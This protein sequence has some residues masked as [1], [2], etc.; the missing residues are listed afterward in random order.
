M[1]NIIY[2]AFFVDLS[3]LEKVYPGVLFRQIKFPHV[4]TAYRPKKTSKSL[5]GRT[6]TIK[7]TGYANDGEKEGVKVT[8]ITDDPELKKMIENIPVPH[9]TISVAEKGKP[10]NTGKLNFEPIE[11]TD[12]I[13]FKGTF[14]GF[15]GEGVNLG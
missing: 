5:Y 4:T 6:V 15:T 10:V 1:G 14:G 11:S 8:V 13:V 9:I 12:E 3:T 2:E 7:V